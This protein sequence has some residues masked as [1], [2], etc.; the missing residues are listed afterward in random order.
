M[1]ARLE[2]A[3]LPAVRFEAM[4][5]DR[6]PTAWVTHTWNTTLNSRFDSAMAPHQTVTMTAGERGCAASHVALWRRCAGHAD[7]GAPLLIMEDDLVMAE[8]F[9][10]R[11][12]ML[13]AAVEAAYPS[14]SE[15][16]LLVYPGAFVGPCMHPTVCRAQTPRAVARYLCPTP[17]GLLT[18]IALP[19]VAST[20]HRLA[21]PATWLSS[22]AARPA[23]GN[24]R[25]TR[26][27]GEASR[28]RVRLADVL[29]SAMAGDG[30]APAGRTPRRR[31]SR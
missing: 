12:C 4:T 17:S 15:R 18:L 27:R 5:G 11:V 6:T 22:E 26:Q 10:E 20:L 29:L 16:A 23:H 3:G 9:G 25:S 24:L 21:R 1:E 30:T 2:A 28:G 14:A 31:A 13:R 8:H 19:R 7:D